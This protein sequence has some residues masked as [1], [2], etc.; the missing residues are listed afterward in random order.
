MDLLKI[1]WLGDLYKSRWFPLVPQVLVLIFFG[2]LVCSGLGVST[3]DP[4]FAKI[5]RNTNLSN[6]I[7]WSYWFPL[8]VIG[9][10]LLGAAFSAIGL[11]A[12]ALTRNQIIAFIV[13]MAVCFI[14]T[15]IDKMLF[16]L[17]RSMLGVLAYLGADFHFQRVYMQ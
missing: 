17:P 4:D 6:L 3:D 14:L 13:G 9:A 10:V 7:V 2:Y 15:L 12:S 5:L 16:F 11:F 1:K 8:I